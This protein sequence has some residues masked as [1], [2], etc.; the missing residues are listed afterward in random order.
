[1]QSL[2]FGWYV[3]CECH[4]NN[5]D[6]EYHRSTIIEYHRSSTTDIECHRSASADVE[7]RRIICFS[8]PH[9]FHIR[10]VIGEKGWG[11]CV[12][13]GRRAHCTVCRSY[14]TGYWTAV[15]WFWQGKTEDSQ[16]MLFQYHFVNCKFLVDCPGLEPR[17]PLWEAVR[18]N[19]IQHG[20]RGQHGWPLAVTPSQL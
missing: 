5:A 14:V 15:D 19:K 10:V 3:H 7:Y 20:P 11:G 18:L 6:A 13:R 2:C 16:K 12:N 4:G 9:P 1:M 17:P 8:S